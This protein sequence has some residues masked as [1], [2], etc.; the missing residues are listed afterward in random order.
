M[1]ETL[2]L[3]RSAFGDE[4]EIT[5]AASHPSTFANIGARVLNSMPGWRGYNAT[6]LKTLFNIN[7]FDV[8]IGVGGGYLRAGN[9][10]EALKTAIIH[11]PQL[12]AASARGRGTVYLPQSVGPARGGTRN[13]LSRGLQRL[14]TVMFRDDRS[15]SEFR[16]VTAIRVPDLAT[17]NISRDTEK[18]VPSSVPVLSIRA[19]RNRVPDAIYGMA[20]RLGGYDAY[21]QSTSSG[22]D[23]RPATKSLD[24]RRILSRSD[25]L[26]L[27][28][29]RRVVV[30]VRLHAA[31]MA[32][33]A[34]HYVVHLAY[35]RK[36]FGA[37]ADL[38]LSNYVH[39][40][41]TF[42]VEK[43]LQQVQALLTDERCRN[44]Y[45]ELLLGSD[46]VRRSM[47]QRYVDLIRQAAAA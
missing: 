23:D 29:P 37:F 35:E 3:I 13:L 46:E 10:M 44:E 2:A 39:N 43:V 40:V 27:E 17:T 7:D 12:A 20:E 25:L 11:G 26:S 22:N 28:G 8:V 6:Y 4:V 30:A 1:R 33:Q 16:D 19:I 24:P 14:Q 5:I 47:R 32:L 42:D 9:P 34:G 15:I 41:N 36:G 18:G 31:L 45:E 21:I 38:G